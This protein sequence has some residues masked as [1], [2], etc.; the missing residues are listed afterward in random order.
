MP[1][2][3]EG[4][5]GEGPYGGSSTPSQLEVPESIRNHRW[6]GNLNGQS[7]DDLTFRGGAVPFSELVQ[8]LET[9]TAQTFNPLEVVHYFQFL[10]VQ[11]PTLRDDFN[12]ANSTTLGPS[13]TEGVL[14]RTAN[15]EVF[16]NQ[17][18]HQSTG[19]SAAAYT[20]VSINHI[21]V[22][23]E[24]SV[25]TTDT[26]SGPAAVVKASDLTSGYV[27]DW[28]DTADTIRFRRYNTGIE[29]LLSSVVVGF[30]L[31]A[32]DR[33][34]FEVDSQP[35]QV[36]LRAWR[37]SSA[38]AWALLASAT[39]TSA[40]RVSGPYN[41]ALKLNGTV[42]RVDNVRADPIGAIPLTSADEI[43]TG[44]A[45]TA[46][47]MRELGQA[48][49]AGAPAAG[50]LRLRK[51]TTGSTVR[52]ADRLRG[53]DSVA[54]AEMAQAISPQHARALTQATETDIAQALT[55]SG[56]K[57]IAQAAETDTANVFTVGLSHFVGN[58][59]ETDTA[60][61]F[62]II[63]QVPLSQAGIALGFGEGGFGTNPVGGQQSGA[64]VANPITSSKS[65]VVTLGQAGAGTDVGFGEGGFGEVGFGGSSQNEF[66]NA[67]TIT[68]FSTVGVALGQAGAG[69]G[70][71]EVGFGEGPFG[72]FPSGI[73][74]I[75]QA[76]TVAHGVSLNLAIENEIAQDVS[77]TKSVLATLGQAS[78]TN[79]AQAL[80][81]THQRAL[82]QALEIDTASALSPFGIN[83]AAETDT[84][85]AIARVHQRSLGQ[86]VETG[87][88]FAIAASERIALLQAAETDTA[89]AEQVVH[90]RALQQATDTQQ[91]FQI[92]AG[93][94]VALAQAVETDTAG[95]IR[96]AQAIR[97]PLA[98]AEETETAFGLSATHTILVALDQALESDTAA[99]ITPLKT[100]LVTVGQALESAVS[101]SVA[102]VHQPGIAAPTETNTAG[103]LTPIKSVIAGIGQTVETDTA[104]VL[105]LPHAAPFTGTTET[106]VANAFAV[107][108]ITVLAQASEAETANALTTVKTLA[109]SQATSTDTAD[110]LTPELITF[111]PIPQAAE[112]NI[113]N[114]LTRTK[115]V[116]LAQA[117]ETDT[118]AVA[119]P[120]ISVPLGTATENNVAQVIGFIQHI[121]IGQAVDVQVGQGVAGQGG[122][123]PFTAVGGDR[124]VT[125]TG[126]TIG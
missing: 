114:D 60:Q 102:P 38:G 105:T 16:S 69:G 79:T 101:T 122:F 120:T 67:F 41:P 11:A 1:G 31:A 5:Y 27:A 77:A 100:I 44:Q 20:W 23:V 39:D 22:V 13:W 74:E 84:A 83:R 106:D 15:A 42:I 8:A 6:A 36:V 89:N 48:T 33:L 86:A 37:R 87:Q 76:I 18:R 29:T 64:E 30:T 88:A 94:T 55:S 61:A 80:S 52:G 3:G 46:R 21:G 117:L 73:S 43:D 99:A 108:H 78:Q 115:Q 66:A 24:I 91:A 92:T 98:I 124:A 119:A 116:A 26:S 9:D 104:S 25:P 82:T 97:I 95:Q 35:T 70:F 63:H 19:P 28:D 54:F 96:A 32:N 72:G 109:L 121:T 40:S 10:D 65:V 53:V 85:G 7:Y 34:G 49:G 125:A 17:A 12:R 93:H 113:A 4:P 90:Q 103:V 51:S 126:F 71:G 2:Y 110:V 57:V 75:G 62:S 50:G 59:A 112:T 81:I 47:H 107:T 14:G 111:T 58:T 123:V 118:A 45:F 56:Q 68:S